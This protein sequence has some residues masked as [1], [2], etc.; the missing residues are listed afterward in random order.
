M[1]E[2]ANAVVDPGAVVIKPGHTLVTGC[3]VLGA[4]RTTNLESGGRGLLARRVS[5]ED[6]YKTSCTEG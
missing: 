3:T 6:T 4:K 5:S 1:V 2:Q